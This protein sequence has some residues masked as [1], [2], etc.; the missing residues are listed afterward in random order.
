MYSKTIYL[1]NI[2]LNFHCDSKE[3][4]LSL[5]DQLKFTKFKNYNKYIEVDLNLRV[6][7]KGLIRGRS[8]VIRARAKIFSLNCW[9]KNISL[10][11]NLKNNKID[12]EL[13]YP[14]I[15]PAETLLHLIILEP[16]QQILINHKIFL[17]HSAVVARQD[18]ALLI[19]AKSEMGKSTLAAAFLM[20]GYNFL[21]DEFAILKNNE[22]L[23]FPLKMK[24]D[25]KSLKSL[26]LN[27]NTRLTHPFYAQDNFKV[28]LLERCMPA[29]I[30]FISKSN[31][32]SKPPQIKALNAQESF[33][34]LAS[35]KK[36]VL[37]SISTRKHAFLALAGLIQRTK[38]YKISY[39]L[40]QVKQIPELID[41]LP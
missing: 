38:S 11:L 28:K 39:H 41:N 3:I 5:C 19:Y 23:S 24:L 34:L 18:K 33:R 21:S 37:R 29:V 6:K 30:L 31:N 17:L 20:A 15:L 1:H 25:S 9:L 12:A 35:D 26:K 8:D 4:F 2:K 16:L 40:N 13:I 7:K 27:K 10:Q 32:P 22:I 36:N 14:C